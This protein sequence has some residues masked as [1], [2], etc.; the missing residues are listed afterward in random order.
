[1]VVERSRNEHHGSARSKRTSRGARS[2]NEHH[3]E[4]EVETN[5]KESVAKTE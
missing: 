5:I 4:R 2:R 3:R 1:M